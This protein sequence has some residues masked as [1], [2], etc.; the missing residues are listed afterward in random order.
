MRPTTIKPSTSLSAA[1]LERFASAEQRRALDDHDDEALEKANDRALAEAILRSLADQEEI[2]LTRPGE[3]DSITDE[4][5]GSESAS[6]EDQSSASTARS[7]TETE[8]EASRNINQQLK[9]WF[10][11]QGFEVVPNSGRNADCLL[12]AMAQHASE[13]YTSEQQSDVA[14][15]REKV[16]TYTLEHH[17]DRPSANDY[18]L[19]SDGNF[20]KELVRAVNDKINDQERK[21]TFC[22]A[23]ADLHGQPSWRKV[24]KGPRMAIIFDQGGH[25]EAVIPKE[26]ST[27]RRHKSYPPR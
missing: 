27:Q 12:I 3:A 17:P 1:Q 13:N 21:I 5:L 10:D 26:I 25:Y 6:A 16:T 14:A 4:S 20:M 9:T 24:G 23:T 22:I 19:H 7:P 2:T 8:Y 18:S 11:Q 15:L